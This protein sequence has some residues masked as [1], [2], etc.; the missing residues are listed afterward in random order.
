MPD[1]SDSDAKEPTLPENA[2]ANA[3]GSAVLNAALEE[4]KLEQYKPNFEAK[5]M[6]DSHLLSLK[7][8]QVKELIPRV[9][10]R[11][12]F[13]NWLEKYQAKAKPKGDDA[14]QAD[15]SKVV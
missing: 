3:N 9:G 4:L 13:L 8:D 2:N 14:A 6:D 1:L 11:M 15:S 7:E 5:S 12:V 10:H